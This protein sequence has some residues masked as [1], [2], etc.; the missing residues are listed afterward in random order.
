M[1]DDDS[2][3]RLFRFKLEFFREFHIDACRIEELKQLC[4]IF[5]IRASRIAK[6]EA[7]SLVALTEELVQIFRIV[8]GD[9]QLFANSFVPQLG[10]GF[11][12]FNTQPVKVKVF[13]G[14]ESTAAK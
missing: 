9:A 8:A 6:A 4:L 14:P 3:S 13:S 1:M 5:E 10:Q 11:G 12:A 7:R 2:R